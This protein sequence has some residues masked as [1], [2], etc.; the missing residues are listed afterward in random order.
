MSRTLLVVEKPADWAPYYP[1]DRVITFAEY[2]AMEEAGSQR[3]RVINLCRSYRYLS[4]GYYCSLLAEARGHHV[5]PSVRTLNELGRRDLFELQLEGLDRALDKA[6]AE[7]GGE[8]NEFILRSFFGTSADPACRDLARALFERFPCPVL[9]VRLKRKK[10]WKIT[11]L[12]PVSHRHLDEHEEDTFA[13]ALDEFSRK[14]WRESRRR[15]QWR[16]DLAILVD[17]DEALP[18]SD[19]PALRRFM[20]AGRKLGIDVELIGRRDYVRVA[21]FDG[22][23]I[24]ETT[25]IDHHTYRFA[26]RAERE[27]LVVVD[28][29]VSILRCTNKIFLADQFRA[30]GVPA[31]RTW[32][33]HKGNGKQLD[34][35]DA[36][37]YPLVLKIPDGSFSRGVSK[38]NSREELEK[39]MKSLFQRSSL[40]LAQE[41]IYTDFDSRIG[42]FNNR[43][44]YACRY[45]M[46]RDHWQI[47]R[48]GQKKSDSGGFDALPVDEVPKAV[49]DAALA[50]ARGIGDGFYGVDV[51]EK[52]GRAFVIEVNDNP[53]I[54]AGVED[55]FPGERLYEQIMA[56][57]LRRMELKKMP[58]AEPRRAKRRDE[59]GAGQ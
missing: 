56:E 5:I 25:A 1:S 24:R 18:P 23:F 9:E 45:Y 17:P 40:L 21:E 15:R 46:V 44:L 3:T 12:R 11:G 4:D 38:V 41:Y 55:A 43:A 28:D 16:Y 30:Q 47:Y 59:S 58:G 42:I 10:H 50:A 7:R 14:V 31:P 19:P 33:L 51:K 22:L 34:E 6:M 8:D 2:L 27:G 26:T 52:D 37:G 54:E 35:L 57:F 36:A 53:S 39:S 48:H 32:L 13:R 29:P 20:R 49:L